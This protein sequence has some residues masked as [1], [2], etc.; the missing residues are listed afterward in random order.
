MPDKPVCPLTA[1]LH[2][3]TAA[4]GPSRLQHSAGLPVSGFLIREGV[5]TVERQNDIEAFILKG[6]CADIALQESTTEDFRS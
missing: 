3:E 4:K 2:T 1:A 6:H 5:K